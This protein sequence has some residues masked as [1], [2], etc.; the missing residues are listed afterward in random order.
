MVA[1]I[2]ETDSGKIVTVFPITHSASKPEEGVEI[3]HQTKSRLGLDD[4]QSWIVTTEANEFVW[5]GPDVRIVSGDHPAYGQLPELLITKALDQ[6]RKH[7]LEL[8]GKT[9]NRREKPLAGKDDP[10]RRM[11]STNFKQEKAAG[12][13]KLDALRQP[14][15]AAPVTGQESIR[16]QRDEE[17][18]DRD[19]PH[20]R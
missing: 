5:P 11:T 2:V 15:P 13:A 19:D 4:R 20:E 14:A 18:H 10:D 17:E 1:N 9:V 3:P 12:R 16:G 8:D 6:S 7:Q